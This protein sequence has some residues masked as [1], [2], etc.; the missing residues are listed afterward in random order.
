MQSKKPSQ[1]GALNPNYKGGIST[2][3]YHYK[4]LQRQRYPE[5]VNARERARRAEKSGKLKPPNKCP[6]GLCRST[7][8]YKHHYNGYEGDKALDV[9]YLCR[10]HHKIFEE[11]K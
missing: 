2:N 7:A 3:H 1:R 8:L 10:K 9:I 11:I 5:R 6:I 4:K